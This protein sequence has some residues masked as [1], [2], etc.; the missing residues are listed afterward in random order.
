MA[1]LLNPA[2]GY[3]I[4]GISLFSNPQGSGP[5]IGP[6]K[7]FATSG[8]GQTVTIPPD[9][10]GILQ[11]AATIDPAF[12]RAGR[13]YLFEYGLLKFFGPT[14]GPVQDFVIQTAQMALI[15]GPVLNPTIYAFFLG[16]PLATTIS[17]GPGQVPILGVNTSFVVLTSDLQNLAAANGLVATSPLNLFVGLAIQNNSTTNTITVSMASDCLIRFI[18]GIY[19]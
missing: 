8:T 11:G 14:A 18:D 2:Y 3:S 15:C 17:P 4:P 6:R 1:A 7:A 10:P 13:G 12:P 9:T 19:G 5:V 16:I